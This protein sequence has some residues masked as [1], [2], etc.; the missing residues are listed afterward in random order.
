MNFNDAKR[1]LNQQNETPYTD[2]EIKE[3]INLLEVIADMIYLSL[4][5]NC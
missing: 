1:I 5:H 4:T 3:I 2:Q